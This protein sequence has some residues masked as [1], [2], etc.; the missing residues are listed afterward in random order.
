MKYVILVPDGMA[1]LP[2]PELG[3]RTPLAAY[4][5]PW[6]DRMASAGTIGLAR[7][8]PAG[9]QPGS[10][11]ANLSILGYDPSEIYTGRAPFEAASMGV[12]L[13]PNDVAFR[14]NFV[15]LDRNYTIMAD[16]SANH[17]SSDEAAQLISVLTPFV[18]S[19]GMHLYPGVSYRHLLVWKNGPDG[20]V[21]YPPHDF[22][23]QLVSPRFPSGPGADKL[24][25]II[26]KSWKVLKDH[27]VNQQR[28]KDCLRPA[29]SVWLWGQGRAPKIRS[30][31]EKYG[32][33]GSV[34]AAV[35]LIKGIGHYAG[36]ATMNVEGATGF[37]DT[38]YEGKVKAALKA[39]NERDLV[40][41]HVEAPDEASHSGDLN[42]KKQAIEDFDRKVVGPMLKGLG[43]FPNWR[44]L[45]MPDHQTPL[46]TRAHSAEPV[47]YILLDSEEWAAAGKKA[48]RAFSEE[49]ALSAGTVVENATRLVELLLTTPRQSAVGE[50]TSG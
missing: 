50:A 4:D 18:E 42:L 5:T 47:P 10:D 6:M 21:T 46:V 35:D 13:M 2:M 30:L 40:F 15:T 29:N 3:N 26:L 44:V 20:C 48:T 24:L 33:T 25:R 9:M 27:P 38:N 23:G 8:V 41:L 12:E 7:T 37:V 34:V 19:L 49:T 36:L 32:I 28:I 22:A 11:V 16:H 14:L 43:A 45:L 17:I 31:R 39:L 1:D